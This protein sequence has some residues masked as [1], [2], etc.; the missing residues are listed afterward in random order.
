MALYSIVIPLYNEEEV[1]EECIKRV[2]TGRLKLKSTI[3]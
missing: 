1:V 2:E 3:L